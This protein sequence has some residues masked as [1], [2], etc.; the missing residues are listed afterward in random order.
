[1]K[2]QTGIECR[3]LIELALT[4]KTIEQISADINRSVSTIKQIKRGSIFNPPI[5]VLEALRLSA[6]GE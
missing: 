5:K 2:R 4:K 6:K 1:M 3:Q